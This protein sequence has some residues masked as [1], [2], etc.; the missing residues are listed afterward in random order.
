MSTGALALAL[1]A[2]VLHASWNAMLKGA[3]DRAAA[4]AGVSATHALAGLAMVL[5]FPEPPPAAWPF[6]ALS[7]TVHYGYYILI[8][9][10]YRLGDLSLAYPIARGIAPFAVALG[11]LVILGED[12]GPAGWAGLAAV[13]AGI[14]LL[15]LAR[16]SAPAALG[17]AVGVAVM[18][19]LV[20][21]TYSVADGIGIRRAG[22]AAL[23]YMGWLFLLEFPVPLAIALRRRRGKAAIPPRTLLAGMAAGALAVTAYGLVLWANRIAPLGAVSAV[24]ESS[25]I[26]AALIGVAAFG[27]G[28]AAP[29]LAAAALVAAGILL[30]ALA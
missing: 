1:L 28:P 22:E 9:H 23:G 29:R 17:G 14:A 15:A 18:T 7:A 5:A 13:S 10:A 6:I 20:I 4:I 30:L 26:V 12:L 24:R 19:G 8:F 3:R 27:E 2:A 21:A 11:A 25:V 16:P